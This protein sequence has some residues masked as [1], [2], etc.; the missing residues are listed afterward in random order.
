M[1]RRSFPENV[2]WLS[3]VLTGW[4]IGTAVPASAQDSSLFNRGPGPYP[5]P[6]V[7]ETASLFYKMPEPLD[8]LEMHDIVTVVVNIN[9]RMLSEGDAE[10]RKVSKLDA[11][12]LDWIV[13]DGLRKVI[14][15]P[16]SAGDPRIQ[17]Q[18]NTQYRAEADVSTRNMITFTLAAKVTDILPNG[19]LR[20]EAR[21]QVNVNGDLW[22]RSLTGIIRRE[23]VTPDN[24]I[25]S[26]D[27]A[28]LQVQTRETGMVRD[29]YRAR[30][31]HKLYDKYWPF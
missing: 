25:L 26:E 15:D 19:T 10:N 7:A 17:A 12:L 4:M 13:L 31:M 23:D 18:L 20:V 9:S 29:S 8:V 28:E 2:F 24:E 14:P 22:E 3:A 6:V 5:T 27:I 30:W 1:L 11:Q 16:Q 21:E